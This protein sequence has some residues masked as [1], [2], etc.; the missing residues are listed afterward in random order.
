M[1]CDE[2]KQSLQHKFV[3]T[4]P[5]V[6]HY[7]EVNYNPKPFISRSQSSLQWLNPGTTFTS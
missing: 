3:L 2:H 5:Q 7:Y 1:I 4:D 6:E